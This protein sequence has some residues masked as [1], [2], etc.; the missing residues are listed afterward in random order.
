M[1]LRRYGA[2]STEE[3]PRQSERMWLLHKAVKVKPKV[4]MR[5]SKDGR[6]VRYYRVALLFYT[7]RN[8]GELWTKVRVLSLTFGKSDSEANRFL[9]ALTGQTLNFQ[10]DINLAALID[11]LC[12]EINNNGARYFF[13]EWNDRGR[14]PLI[15]KMRPCDRITSIELETRV[16]PEDVDG[17]WPT[18]LWKAY[19][20]LQDN[21][22]LKLYDGPRETFKPSDTMDDAVFETL[23]PY[24]SK[25][26]PLYCD[27]VE[28]RVTDEQRDIFGLFNR[29]Y[30]KRTGSFPGGYTVE[31]IDVLK[32]VA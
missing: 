5:K 18:W 22:Q 25:E 11:E 7:K 28:R 24:V 29:A 4:L 31:I 13:I 10:N 14:Y 26:G 19:P 6:I 20:E 17:T 16:S 15:N 2:G 9:Q 27:S 3:T 21:N 23:L 30:Y 12:D 1:D 8:D 32:S